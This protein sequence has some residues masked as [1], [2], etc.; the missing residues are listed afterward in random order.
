MAEWLDRSGAPLALAGLCV[1]LVLLLAGCGAVAPTA[2]PTPAVVALPLR[3]VAGTACPEALMPDVRLV[4]DSAV[5]GAL[6][7]VAPNGERIPLVFREGTRAAVHLDRNVIELVFP[8]GDRV[9]L[10]PEDTVSFGGGSEGG[11]GDPTFFA[12]S[13]VQ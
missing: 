13:L 2:S 8:E 10:G 5:P 6:V 4:A 1:A 12:C 7:A 3:T 9:V 11:E